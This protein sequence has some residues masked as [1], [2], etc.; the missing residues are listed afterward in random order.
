MPRPKWTFMKG[1]D[2]II[3]QDRKINPQ[4]SYPMFNPRWNIGCRYCEKYEECKDFKGVND[5][6]DYC[7]L[8]VVS[9]KLRRHNDV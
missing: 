3:Y 9:F 1:A 2:R 7:H 6:S 8:S 5:Q 4:H